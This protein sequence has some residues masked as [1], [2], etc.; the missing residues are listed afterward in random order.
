MSYLSKDTTQTIDLFFRNGTFIKFKTF[1]S[2]LERI[3]NNTSREYTA[4]T[5]LKTL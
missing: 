3:Y 5:K 2:L 1:I 4:I